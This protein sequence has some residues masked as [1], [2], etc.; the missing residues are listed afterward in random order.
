M[1]W[2][3]LDKGKNSL[4]RSKNSKASNVCIFAIHVV[5]QNDNLYHI[6]V[7]WFAIGCHNR[8]EGVEVGNTYKH[9]PSSLGSVET[10]NVSHPSGFSRAN[11]LTSWR[12]LGPVP[13]RIEIVQGV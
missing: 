7:H 5:R 6:R 3:R 11:N 1:T 2:T 9:S 8:V 12:S 13:A 10:S 4:Q